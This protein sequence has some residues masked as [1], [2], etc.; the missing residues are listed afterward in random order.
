VKRAFLLFVL[1]AASCRTEPLP[2]G[3]GLDGGTTQLNF[4]L[5]MASCDELRQQVSSLLIAPQ[6]C[7]RDSD[8]EAIG[9]ACGLAG[10]C[11]A[12]VNQSTASQVDQLVAEYNAE[13]CG[14]GQA[15]PGC[16]APPPFA[17]CNHGLC[18]P[19]SN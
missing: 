10:V 18:G 7:G 2:D 8:C 14:A 17:A 11:G 1:L 16:P 13:K 4:D 6:K 5:S 15:C 3:T 12:Y 19:P 9:T